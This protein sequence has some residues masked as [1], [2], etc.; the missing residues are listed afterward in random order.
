MDRFNGL[1]VLRIALGT[2]AGFVAGSVLTGWCLS[3]HTPYWAG[4][5]AE[6]VTAGGTW[7]AAIA[8]AIAIYYAVSS[9]ER[10]IRNAKEMRD[11]DELAKAND[12][13]ARAQIAASAIMK[14]L[15]TTLARIYEYRLM[16]GDHQFT[17]RLPTIYNGV[18]RISTPVLAAYAFEGEV[19]GTQAGLSFMTAWTEIEYSKSVSLYNAGKASEWPIDF[20]K[21]RGRSLRDKLRSLT[22]V[23]Q[24]AMYAAATMAKKPADPVIRDAMLHGRRMYV[25]KRAILRKSR[26]RAR[27]EDETA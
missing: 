5:G 10:A 22:K 3:L 27:T 2:L 19:F 20:Q 17:K 15:Q 26:E 16:L 21:L 25:D 24:S 23:L 1:T 18:G 7:V 14:E 11:L 6:W 9:G 8:T 4:K 12:R 13:E